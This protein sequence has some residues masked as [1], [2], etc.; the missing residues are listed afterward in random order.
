MYKYYNY[1][2]N[3]KLQSQ[4]IPYGEY[5]KEKKEKSILQINIHH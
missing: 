1:N 2:N 5:K 3:N 4:L